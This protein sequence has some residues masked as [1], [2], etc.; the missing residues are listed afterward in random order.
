MRVKTFALLGTALLAACGQPDQI[1]SANVP[2]AEAAASKPVSEMT[3]EQIL[4]QMTLER[5]IAQ[6]VMP[7]ISTITPEDVKTYRFG[8]ILNGGNSGPGGDD[9]APAIE[10]LKLADEVWDAS[11]APLANGEPVIPTLWATD[12]VH[13]HSNVP[14]ATIFPHNI[15]LGATK[16][17]GLMQRIG[18]ATAAEIAATGIDWTFAPTLAVAT[19]DRW[20]RTYESFSEDAGLV[21]ALG[22]P[23]IVGLQGEQGTAEFLDASRVIATAKHF[24]G[25]GGTNGKDRGD[26]R[27]TEAELRA[28]HLAPYKP[29][30]DAGV[31]TVMA[32]F[33]SVNGVKMHGSKEMLTGTLRDE[34]GF[35]GL[36]VGDWNG[37][38]EL[39]GCSNSDC[40]ESL[41]AGLD[42]FMVPEDWKALY[43]TLLRQARDGTIPMARVDEAV[44]RILRV[45]QAYNHFEKGRPSARLLGGK[46]E[47][48]GSAEHRAIARQAVRESLVLLKNNGVLPLKSSANIVVDGT[49]ADSVAKQSGGW[50]ITWQGGGDLTNDNF[51]GATTIFGGIAEAMTG[52]GGKAH[53]AG[54]AGEPANPDAAIIVFGEEP[55]AEF[56][57]DRDDY[58]FRDEE[59]LE[60]LKAYKAK[61]IPTVAVFLSGRAMWMN[62]ELAEA[63]AFVAAWLPGSE[64]AGIADVLIGD[65]AGAPRHDFTGKLAFGWPANCAPGSESLFAYGTGWSYASAP[66]KRSFNTECALLD[67]GFEDGLTI[68]ERGLSQSVTAAANDPSG[69]ARLVNLVGATKSGGLSVTAF[70]RAAQEDARRITWTGPASL[71]F[72]WGKSVLPEE[73]TLV[74]Q[75]NVASQPTGSITLTPNCDGCDSSVDLT[76]SLD[77]AAGKGWRN[78]RIPLSCIDKDGLTGVKLAS[79]S[80]FVFGVDSIGIVPQATSEDC[81]GPF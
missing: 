25:D 70:D 48:L 51:P 19:D 42:I 44:L 69:T 6:L 60:L 35:E 29:A 20:G 8:S 54:S 55:Y 65:S 2:T 81:T 72:D 40:P 17:P 62:R 71:S 76:S 53:L 13:G 28:T 3:A 66:A 50:S 7:D 59:G 12:A 24:Y 26:T 22:T 45:K 18:K 57:G 39:A 77:L 52:T 11:T 15:G 9:E 41:M 38:G 16:N 27:G 68:F 33:S 1:R 75:V 78:I 34:L 80:A 43:N 31:Q 61:G 47:I 58:A 4:A 32:S 63:D 23:T 46:F 37:H 14:G 21:T 49:G 64:G 10:W 74:M 30:I 73:G 67:Q 36:V 79:E 56:V 5:K